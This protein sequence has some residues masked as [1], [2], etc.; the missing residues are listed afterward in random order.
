MKDWL[1]T[2]ATGLFAGCVLGSGVATIM[3]YVVPP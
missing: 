3:S 2:L 1:E